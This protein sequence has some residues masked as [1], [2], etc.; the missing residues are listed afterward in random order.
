MEPDTSFRE[1]RTRTRPPALVGLG[2][3]EHTHLGTNTSGARTEKST[4]CCFW[5]RCH[6]QSSGRGRRGRSELPDSAFVLERPSCH[7]ALDTGPAHGRF[8]ER[9]CRG[10]G[11]SP[12][13]PEAHQGGVGS[14]SSSVLSLPWQMPTPSMAQGERPQVAM[15]VPGASPVHKCLKCSQSLDPGCSPRSHR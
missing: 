1:G 3:A 7:R 2:L 14:L 15:Q 9:P 10:L 6:T 11:W 12:A 4:G 13:V 5:K 8:Q